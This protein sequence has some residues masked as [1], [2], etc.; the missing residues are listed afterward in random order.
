MLSTGSPKRLSVECSAALAA[1]PAGTPKNLTEVV[2]EALSDP[3]LFCDHVHDDPDVGAAAGI[4]RLA[5]LLQVPLP[6]PAGRSPREVLD[7]MFVLLSECGIPVTGY[8]H[9]DLYS[10][11]YD[12]EVPHPMR[13]FVSDKAAVLSALLEDRVF[14]AL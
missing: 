6:V 10:L 8:L 1:K 5:H 4:A 12:M 7:R 14:D 11:V 2:T 13:G 9:A 3:D